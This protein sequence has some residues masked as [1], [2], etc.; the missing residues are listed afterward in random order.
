[1]P[2]CLPVRRVGPWGA[3]EARRVT[4]S[5]GTWPVT[6]YVPRVA[7]A[8]GGWGGGAVC[9]PQP[10]PTP[11]KGGPP[12][13]TLCH[14]DTQSDPQPPP[15]PCPNHSSGCSC[16]L[17]AVEVGGSIS[18]FRRRRYVWP[19]L[20]RSIALDLHAFSSILQAAVFFSLQSLCLLH[21]GKP[22]GVAVSHCITWCQIQ[23][24]FT[25]CQIRYHT[26]CGIIVALDSSEP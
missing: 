3:W 5:S 15:P 16:N 12:P 14:L 23:L 18:W 17:W 2:V 26:H 20:R 9:F 21:M 8:P 7:P 4:R 24:F 13:R 10:Y 6:R 19:P 25:T 22:T 1:M 11:L